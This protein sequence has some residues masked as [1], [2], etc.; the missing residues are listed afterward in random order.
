M[1]LAEDI[2]FNKDTPFTSYSTYSQKGFYVKLVDGTHLK[3]IQI[4]NRDDTG[5][6]FNFASAGKSLIFYYPWH[7]INFICWEENV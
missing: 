7:M 5:I 3:E 4:L 2:K 1:S 6:F